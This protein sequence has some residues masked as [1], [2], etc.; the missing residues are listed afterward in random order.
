MPFRIL[1]YVVRILERHVEGKTPTEALPLPVVI[2][3]VLHHSEGRWSPA[4]RLEDLFD[5]DLVTRAALHELIPRLSFVLDDLSE[6]PDEVLESRA[7]GLVPSLTLWALR[8][9][10][11]P[12]RL[13]QSIEHWANAMA[14]LLRAPNG[15]EALGTLFRYITL[16][17]D[18]SLAS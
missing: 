4:R 2:P 5:G 7:L 9:A 1:R 3:V 13:L 12:A 14:E 10:R 15:R 6:L 17:A 16:V 18:D 8:D 11:N